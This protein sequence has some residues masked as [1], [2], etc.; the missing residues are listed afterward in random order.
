MKLNGDQRIEAGRE[1]VWQALNDPEVLK[2]SIPGCEALT[3]EGENRFKAVVAVKVGPIGARFNGLVELSDLN[4]PKSYRLSGE[5]QGGVAGS[6]KGSADIRLEEDGEAT[7]LIY[8]VEAQVGGRMAQLGGAIIDAT[9]RQ[10]AGRFFTRF[11]EELNS[12]AK[13]PEAAAQDGEVTPASPASSGTEAAPVHSVAPHPGSSGYPSMLLLLAAMLV[14]YALGVFQARAD[15][16]GT[17]SLV[18][19]ALL[20]TVG[21]LTWSSG[22]INAS[23][24]GK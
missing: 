1:A 24:A 21:I 12:G 7:R 10:L 13:V 4:P 5:G 9:A 18:V 22:R 3:Q 20:L 23:G 2:R 17:D 11:A 6:A 19:L 16:L 15:L 8:T 14:T